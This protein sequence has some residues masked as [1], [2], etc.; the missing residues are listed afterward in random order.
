MPGR[1]EIQRKTFTRWV[2]T[3][4]SDRELQVNDIQ[5]DFEDGVLLLNLLEIIS[6]EKKIRGWKKKPKSYAQKMENINKGLKFI[7][8]EGVVIVNIGA[9]DISRG[10]LS[11]ILG[12]IWTLILRYQI[13]KCEFSGE[14]GEAAVEAK[15]KKKKGDGVK[16]ELL[17]WVNEQL[18]PYDKKVKN[19]KKDWQDPQILCALCD[20]LRPGLID[21]DKIEK[22]A[23][24]PDA[25]RTSNINEAMV[26]AKSNFEI[27]MVMDASDMAMLP[28]EL[29][30]MTYVSYFRDAQK[31]IA[32]KAAAGGKSYAEGPGLEIGAEGEPG[33]F[34]VHCL[35]HEGTP[36]A[37]EDEPIVEITIVDSDGND[38]K[39]DIG[40]PCSSKPGAYQCTYPTEKAGTYTVTVKVKGATLMGFPKEVLIH[41]AED[42]GLKSCKFQFT[43]HAYN[44]DDEAET[45]GGDL[46]EVDLKNEKGQTFEVVKKDNADG[47]YT[48]SYEV[49]P[50][51]LYKVFAKLNGEPLANC[52][53]IHDLRTDIDKA[54]YAY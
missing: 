7:K 20:S 5:K 37:K 46:F 53:L 12:L 19:F 16:K 51:H 17:K 32:A 50:G 45:E 10:N 48:A 30:V 38:V 28:D 3:H 42:T 6:G 4:L 11:I 18:E 1:T 39:C 13:N 29:S 24:A 23:K 47:T 54:V 14:L 43:I 52:P 31:D 49:F 2:N 15:K 9:D 34:I 36:M 44:D 21:L 41:A 35:T 26:K 8:D 25:K 40:D 27:P 22:N 33:E